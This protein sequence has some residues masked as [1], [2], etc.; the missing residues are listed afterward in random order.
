[1]VVDLLRSEQYLSLLKNPEKLRHLVTALPP[2]SWVVIDEVQKLPILLDEVHALIADYK[3]KYKFALTGSSARKLKRGNA[4]MLAGRAQ[5]HQMYALTVD[6][7]GSGVNLEA[8]LKYG[9]LPEVVTQSQDS[10]RIE[11]LQ[12]YVQTYLKEEIQMETKVRDLLG[13]TRFLDVAAIMNGQQ[14]NL[15]NIAREV[16][17]A[18]STVQGHFSILID[19]LLGTLVDAYQPRAKV[20]EVRL[21]KFYF[22]DAGIVNA[23]KGTLRS[24]LDAR[25]SGTLFET[26]FLNKLRALN[27]YSRYGGSIYY[28]RTADGNEVDFI[29]KIG[30][31]II[32]FEVKSTTSWKSTYNFGLKTLLDKKTISRG[33][34][35]YAG[36][37]ILKQ[38]DITILPFRYFSAELEKYL[39]ES[40]AGN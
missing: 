18:R 12:S 32:G 24:P 36:D 1:M 7:L 38:D 39:A 19:T 14:L 30:H 22:F 11:F 8:L 2:Q 15:S 17:L 35:I 27:S 10:D 5:T 3:D 20:K 6:E 40:S 25:D 21:P 33:Y 23:L 16:G 29:L 37:V 4:N 34:G 28:W 31:K 9:S 26:L 13:L